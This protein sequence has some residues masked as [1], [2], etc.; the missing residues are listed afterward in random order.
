[1]QLAPSNL[2]ALEHGAEVYR[3]YVLPSKTN[4]Q[5]VGMHYAVSSIFE[6]DPESFP[7]FNY[8]TSNEVFVRKDAGEQKLVLGITNVRSN[9]TRSE[10]RFAF[11]VVYIG[12]HN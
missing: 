1:M 10:K 4:L 11:A 8:T 9:V 3:K 5:R 6:E 2:T 12:K 7:V